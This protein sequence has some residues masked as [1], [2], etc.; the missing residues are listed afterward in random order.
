MA[1]RAQCTCVAILLAASPRRRAAGAL[2]HV[3]QVV[4]M[5]AVKLDVAFASVV[6]ALGEQSASL[7]LDL[8]TAFAYSVLTNRRNGAALVGARAVLAQR[9]DRHALP[10]GSGAFIG[11]ATLGSALIIERTRRAHGT[12]SGIAYGRKRTININALRA[13]EHARKGDKEQDGQRHK[14][15]YG[16]HA[17]SLSYNECRMR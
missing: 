1:Q 10:A 3:A 8:A 17:G 16:F 11:A 7:A 14:R 2:A 5:C 9:H 15:A 12:T 13:S 4:A 6:A